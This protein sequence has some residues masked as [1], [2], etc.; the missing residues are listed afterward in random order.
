MVKIKSPYIDG[1]D[2]NFIVRE[3]S[4]DIEEEDLVWHR[5]SSDRLVEVIEGD[6]WSIQFENSLPVPLIKNVSYWIEN[7]EWHRL[8]KGNN[9][10]VLKILEM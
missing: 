1:R 5:D 10:L 8:I 4:S 3:F 2:K 7:N 6:C 9:R